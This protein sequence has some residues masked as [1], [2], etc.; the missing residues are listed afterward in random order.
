MRPVLKA[1]MSY[2]TTAETLPPETLI[3]V[4]LF[5]LPSLFK[6]LLQI[7][8]GEPLESPPEHSGLRL[9]LQSYLRG[10]LRLLGECDEEIRHVVVQSMTQSMELV[11][12][13]PALRRKWIRALVTIWANCGEN[14]NLGLRCFI[15]FK[16]AMEID[17]EEFYIW[18]LRR[19]YVGYF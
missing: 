18:V 12:A 15:C 13:F 16:K 14:L 10:M 11:S 2:S 19:I 8:Q 1:F 7:N 9:C 6:N 5:S 3:P 4:C 17:D